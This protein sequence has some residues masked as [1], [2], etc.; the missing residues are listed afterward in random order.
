MLD[1]SEGDYHSTEEDSSSFEGSSITESPR[2][3]LAHESLKGQFSFRKH[4]SSLKRIS[5]FLRYPF[6]TDTKKPNG[7]LPIKEQPPPLLKCFSYVELAN[8]TNNF[9]QGTKLILTKCEYL[10]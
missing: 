8:A 6:E 4:I 3:Q 10:I 5:S 2:P 7:K 1:L 9:H